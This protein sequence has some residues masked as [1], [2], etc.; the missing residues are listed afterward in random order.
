MSDANDRE[1]TVA[2]DVLDRLAVL[3]AD[4]LDALDDPEEHVR[5]A[6]ENALILV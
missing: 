5:D 1:R 3:E 2:D 6:A 4:A